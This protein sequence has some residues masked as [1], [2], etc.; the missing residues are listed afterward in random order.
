[1][2]DRRVGVMAPDRW[3]R[4]LRAA[5]DEFAQAGYE[6]ASL[7]RIIRACGLSKSSFYHYV[8]SKEQLF[9]RVLWAYGPT[10]IDI[11][12]L[13]SEEELA[14][15]F[16]G[17]L[18]GIVDRLAAAGTQDPIYA[19]IGRM[20]YL[21]GAPSAEKTALGQGFAKVLAWLHRAIQ[22]GRQARAVR[23]DLPV[24]LQAQVVLAV[25]RVFDEWS[26]TRMP[27]GGEAQQRL[28]EAQLAAIQRLIGTA[29]D[30]S[31]HSS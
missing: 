6:Q 17:E 26:L 14:R 3:D 23:D 21:P 28:I 16:W 9:E 30:Q 13:P 15:D 2:E 1:M 22:V 12:E 24:E 11:L 27:A 29:L 10:L 20:C 18:D 25:L 8:A 31:V 7:N 19:L 4:L 5:A